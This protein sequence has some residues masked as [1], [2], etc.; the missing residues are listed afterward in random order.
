MGRGG[1]AGSLL[2]SS[3]VNP[4]NVLR[5][6]PGGGATYNGRVFRSSSRAAFLGGL[7]A[8]AA[9]VLPAAATGEGAA[10]EDFL[11]AYA[12]AEPA[13]REGIARTFVESV[14]AATGFPLIGEA[15]T[16]DGEAGGDGDGA[17]EVTFVYAGAGG[18]EEVR[19]VGDFRQAS[20]YNLAWD[21]DGVALVRAAPQGGVF[22]ARLSFEA[23]ARVDYAFV[24]DGEQTPDP[25]NPRTLFSGS[26]GGEVSELVMPAYRPAPEAQPRPGLP[27]GT[28][29]VVD[30]PWAQPK[31]TV[32]LPPGYDQQRR[33]PTVYTADGSAWIEHLRLPTILDN[34]IAGGAIEPLIAVMV[35]AAPDR[36]AWY[37]YN[38]AFPAYLDR[39]VAHVDAR[40]ATDARPGRRL[41][42]GTSAGARAS[43]YAALERP[44]LFAK[45]G[46]LSPSLYGPL[47]YWQP[48]FSGRRPP[49]PGL[50]LWLSAGTYEGVIVDDV[51]RLATHFAGL[52]HPVHTVTTHEGHSFGTWRNLVGEMLRHFF[53]AR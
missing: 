23:D 25:L 22:Y 4:E 11:A 36:G 41:H 33:Y 29:Q 40:Y 12:G 46:L 27:R 7:L 8:A 6:Y 10:F 21:R 45:A 5:V 44:G 1:L 14:Q 34:L 39:V 35:D 17:H 50:A 15:V 30:E 9:G 19:L 20:H 3:T 42:A 37:Y 51:E 43:L 48:L 38:P 18:E 53:P 13:E 47:S 28:L 24:V 16:G 49:P 52:G 2:Y 26:G 31:V 32:Y